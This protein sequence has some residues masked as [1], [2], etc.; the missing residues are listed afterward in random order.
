[1][2]YLHTDVG[3]APSFQAGFLIWPHVSCISCFPTSGTRTIERYR[4]SADEIQKFAVRFSTSKE[5]DSFV[6]ILKNARDLQPISYDFGSQISTLL[7]YYLQID[8]SIGCSSRI[9]ISINYLLDVI[10]RCNSQGNVHD[11]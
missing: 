1:M 6:N 3:R 7:S 8:C 2:S 9:C 5:T 11:I 10:W 4:D